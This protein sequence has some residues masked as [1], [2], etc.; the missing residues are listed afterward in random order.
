[1]RSLFPDDAILDVL[2]PHGVHVRSEQVMTVFN[3]PKPGLMSTHGLGTLRKRLRKAYDVVIYL[4]TFQNGMSFDNVIR[5][6]RHVGTRV[7]EYQ[8]G[9]HMREIKPEGFETTKIY[10]RRESSAVVNVA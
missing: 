4:N 7:Y 2:A 8:A 5:L 3:Y 6:A 1:V 10:S 9:R